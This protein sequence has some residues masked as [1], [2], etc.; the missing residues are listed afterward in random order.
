VLESY[1]FFAD[2]VLASVAH[3]NCNFSM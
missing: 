1:W 2:Y 3:R